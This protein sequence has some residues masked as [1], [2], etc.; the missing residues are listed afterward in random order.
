MQTMVRTPAV[1]LF[2]AFVSLGPVSLGACSPDESQLSTDTSGSG[3]SSGSAVAAASG[4]GGGTIDGQAVVERY[5]YTFDTATGDARSALS[6]RA[7][8]AGHCFA[9]ASDLPA[10]DVAFD[11][12]AASQFELVGGELRACGRLVDAA[13]ATVL[14]ADVTVP[15]QTYLGLDVG[16]SRKPSLAGGTFSYLLSWVGGCPHFGPCDSHPGRLALFDF[17][18]SH[19]AGTTVLCPGSIAPGATSTSC[20]LSATLAPTY[21][22]FFVAADTSWV[23][24]PFLSAAGVEMVFYEAPGGKLATALDTAAVA[25]FMVWITDRLGPYPYGDELRVA[26]APTAW[27]GFEHPANIILRDDL[28]L[29]NTSYSDTTMHVLMHEI[30][31]QWAGDRTTLANAADFVWKEATCEYLAYLFEETHGPAG[32]ADATRAYWHKI[33]P[34]AKFHPRPRDEPTPPI[35]EFYGGSYGPG[36]MVLYLQLEALIGAHTVLQAI[37]AFLS[38]PGVR[39]V[40][41][42]KA[43]LE[44][45]SGQDLTAYF[46]AWVFGSGAPTWPSFSVTTDQQADQVTV[47]VTQDGP[48]IF[49]CVVEIDVMSGSETVTAV[50]DFGHSPVSNSAQTTVSLNGALTGTVLDPRKRVIHK[51]AGMAHGP[52]PKV[53]IF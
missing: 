34:S 20:S 13:E 2:L 42:L 1:M 18:V 44:S 38:E 48:E 40:A 15:E 16:F 53:W 5:S 41:D 14:S 24:T 4:T 43:E 25:D 19:P 6:M 37:S 8:E 22:A 45:A 32:H 12:Q 27:L 11:G 10:S 9:L 28:P 17:E 23:R 7:T 31:H 50:V 52:P 47:T 21:S 26:G 51:L 46:D 30:I 33:A 35:E 49:G 3:G 36:P 29:L 39:G